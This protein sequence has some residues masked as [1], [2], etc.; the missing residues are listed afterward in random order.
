MTSGANCSPRPATAATSISRSTASR[1]RKRIEVQMPQGL[2][3]LQLDVDRWAINQPLT[4][5]AGALRA[6]ARRSSGN[7]PFVDLADPN[8]V[9]PGQ[10]VPVAQPGPRRPASVPRTTIASGFAA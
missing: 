5:G 8:F 2:L 4:E 6:A 7:Y 10:S 1:C 3:R 9:P